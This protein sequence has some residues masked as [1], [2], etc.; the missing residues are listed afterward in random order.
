MF[1]DE[2]GHI[3]ISEDE[4]IAHRREQLQ[5]LPPALEQLGLTS[6]PDV[7]LPQQKELLRSTSTHGLTVADKSRRVGF[8]WAIGSD[9]VLTAGAQKSA[10]GMDCLYIGYNLDMAREFIDCC[11]MWARAF[12]PA[13]TET[14]EFLFADG[15]DAHGEPRTIQA[16]RIG[17]AS[18]FEIIALSSRPRSLRGRQGYVILDEFA[19][20]DDAEGLLKAAMAFLIWGGKVLVISTHNGIDN[21]F[22]ALIEEIRAGKRPGN[23]VRCTFD[24]A[25][26]QGLYRR[27]CLVT[28]REWTAEGEA[29]WR[30]EIYRT[31]GADSDEELRCIPSLGTGAYLSRALIESRMVDGIP[32]IRWR[33]PAG[34]VDWPTRIWEAE[35]DEF[36]DRELKPHLD[37]LDPTL[38]SCL[39]QDFARSG[40]LSVIHPVQIE[41]TLRRRPPFILELDD[42]PYSAQSRIL[43]YIIDR[44]PRFFHAAFDANGN[45]A[46][47]A[48]AARQKCGSSRVSEIKPS[49]DFYRENMP[50][51]RAAF[52][53]ATIILPRDDDIANDYRA[54]KMTRGIAKVPENARTV[55]ANGADRHGDAAI[56]GLLAWYASL[57]RG[58]EGA[59]AVAGLPRVAAAGTEAFTFP[60]ELGS[61]DDFLRM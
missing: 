39:G 59:P 5:R 41:Q 22:N 26:E 20:H 52:E 37:A 6:L 14:G 46:S 56:A 45:G 23:I 11:A 32:V 48:E 15:T 4:W 49:A 28:G 61:L 16:F 19:F 44:L 33:A 38:R 35:V 10:R 51:L 30:A 21:P 24:D 43:F 2:A 18:G 1:T 53:D 50:K 7:L 13:C 8:T 31:Y 36:C 42:V 54:I 27:V 34:M 3:P 55:G 57:Q 25:I 40:D 9:A 60:S 58:S 47:H 17:F 29:K 12:M